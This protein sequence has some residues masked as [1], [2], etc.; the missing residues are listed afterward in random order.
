MPL[1]D[2][3]PQY[4]RA[5][6]YWSWCTFQL[7]SSGRARGAQQHRQSYPLRAQDRMACTVALCVHSLC[8][9]LLHP[10]THPHTQPSVPAQRNGHGLRAHARAPAR[11]RHG[12]QESRSMIFLCVSGCSRHI[13]LGLQV[14]PHATCRNTTERGDML[15]T[16][17]RQA[18]QQ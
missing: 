11:S 5:F 9:A 8:G 16:H 10:C 12:N 3:S 7:I 14:P 18:Q 4:S 13:A 15:V 17:A 6:C 1:D 2:T